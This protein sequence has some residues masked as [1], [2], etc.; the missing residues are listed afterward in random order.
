M[1]YCCWLVA[2]Q[3][4]PPLSGKCCKLLQKPNASSRDENAPVILFYGLALPDG[5]RPWRSLINRY[6]RSEPARLQRREFARN[7]DTAN[8]FNLETC[9]R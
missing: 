5:D 1:R 2:R 7:F 8:L 9:F 3:T 4:T 6:L